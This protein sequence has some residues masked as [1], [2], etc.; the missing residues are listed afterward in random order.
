MTG[1][2]NFRANGRANSTVPRRRLALAAVHQDL[3]AYI[4]RY[5]GVALIVA[6]VAT[7]KLSH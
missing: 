1:R 7:L 2:Y 3:S 4:D 5:L 6:G